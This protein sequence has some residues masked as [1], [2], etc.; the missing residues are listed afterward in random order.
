MLMVTLDSYICPLKYIYLVT[1]LNMLL[2]FTLNNFQWELFQ[3]ENYIVTL[4]L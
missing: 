2:H 4:I 1:A 3:G